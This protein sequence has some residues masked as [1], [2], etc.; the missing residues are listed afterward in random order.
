MVNE[1]NKFL[2]GSWLSGLLS[3]EF[4]ISTGEWEGPN[5]NTDRGKQPISAVRVS[6]GFPSNESHLFLCH[7]E[8]S[9]EF[10]GQ[11]LR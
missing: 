11:Y 8:I 1:K 9:V 6:G 7:N 5:A 10:V 3:A 4:F 2:T